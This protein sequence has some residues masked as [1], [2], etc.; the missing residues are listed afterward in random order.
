[1]PGSCA[2]EAPT[3]LDHV[4]TCTALS[5]HLITLRA[6]LRYLCGVQNSSLLIPSL[7]FMQTADGFSDQCR[8]KASI[9]A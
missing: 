8:L 5:K 3:Y 7:L 9:S 2:V 4:K 6:S 1:M